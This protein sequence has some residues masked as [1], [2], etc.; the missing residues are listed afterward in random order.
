MRKVSIII[1]TYNNLSLTKECLESIK[2]YTTNVPY[3]I[4]IVDNYS[5]DGTREWLKNQNE[6]KVILNDKNLGF[7]KGCNIGIKEASKDSDILLLNNDTIV[8]E[9][10]LCNLKKCLDSSPEIGAVGAVCNQYENRQGVSFN[11]TNFE[12]MQECAKLNNVSDST[13][14]EEKNFLIGFC[15]LIKREVI[16]KIKYL[17]EGYTPGYI[18]DNDLCLRIIKLGYKLMLCH[19]AFIH[20]YLG[21]AFRKDLNKFYP[22]L[23][24]NRDYFYKKWKF[25][26]FAFDEMKN[27][28]MF[29]ECKSVLDIDCGIGS[30]ILDLKYKYKNME[31]EGLEK[32]K[33]KRA[34]S[35]HFAKVYKCLKDVDKKY[36]CILLGN[37]LEKVNNPLRF[38]K[39]I[40]KYLNDGGYLIGEAQNANNIKNLNCLLNNKS[41]DLFKDQKSIYTSLDIKN[42]LEKNNFQVSFYFWYDNLTFEENE[43]Y[44][45]LKNR[46]EMIRYTSFSFKAKC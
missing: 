12:E 7:P 18:E 33:N 31:V 16:N 30:T 14:W 10:W 2:K 35:S 45:L 24:K 36:D 8:T 15:L 17:D 44:E 5:N 26:T 23:Y 19:D 20:H 4:I 32:N 37:Y 3:E 6:Y 27:I 41:Y 38:L 39:M 1:L 9:N 28:T 46:T 34:I 25:S 29:T 42:I 13:K 22:I 11:Y 21:T 43:L 40:K